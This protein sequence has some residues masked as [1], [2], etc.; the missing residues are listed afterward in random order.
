MTA[1]NS[2]SNRFNAT[3][4]SARCTAA[5]ASAAR[6]YPL[7]DAAMHLVVSICVLCLPLRIFA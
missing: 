6:I 2:F 3:M 5:A 1:R 4:S 7:L